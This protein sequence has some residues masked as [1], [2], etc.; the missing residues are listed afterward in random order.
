M[1]DDKKDLETMKTCSTCKES[2]SLVC[3]HKDRT[4]PDGLRSSCIKCVRAFNKTEEGVMLRRKY[5]ANSRKK[6]IAAPII[7]IE[8]F[9]CRTCKITQPITAFAKDN[10]NKYGIKT[11]CKSCANVKAERYRRL[12]AAKVLESHREYV[13]R[14]PELQKAAVIKYRKANPEVIQLQ[15]R[16][17]RLARCYG[18]T[19]EQFEQMLLAQDNCC[20]ICLKELIIP[21]VDHDHNTNKIRGLLCSSCNTGIGHL[22]DNVSNLQNAIDYLNRSNN[23]GD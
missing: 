9:T 11:Y 8:T 10:A 14:N 7:V 20:P 19:L 5:A 17:S 2:L 16:S 23:S 3:F 21:C 22:K 12:N 18:L 6:R 15:Q 1:A 13:R 4:H